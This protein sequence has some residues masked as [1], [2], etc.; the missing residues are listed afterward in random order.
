MRLWS[1]HPKYL[2]TP[3]LL[4]LWREGLLAKKVLEGN[5][6][7]YKNHPQLNRFKEHDFPIEA[8]N[9]YLEEVFKESKKRNFIFNVSKF[10]SIDK[11]LK[12]ITITTGQAE[13][14][15]KHLQNK[16]KQR[17]PNFYKK[18]SIKNLEPHPMFKLKFGEI[19][20][21]EKI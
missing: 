1:I 19:E 18:V 16:I 8:I 2:D 7:G 21:W 5:T 6:K 12:K 14:E 15:L 9:K 11:K 10:K 20:S 3:G 4:A 13:Y 17:S